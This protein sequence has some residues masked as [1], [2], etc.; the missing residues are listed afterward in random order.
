MTDQLLQ[1]ATSLP[2]DKLTPNIVTDLWL[3]K[4]LN[5]ASGLLELKK[6]TAVAKET[7]LAERALHSSLKYTVPAIIL[8]AR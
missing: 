3:Y 7:K 6:M 8:Q 2:A 4:I 5:G 1:V